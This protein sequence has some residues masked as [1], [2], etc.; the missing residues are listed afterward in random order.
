MKY[1]YLIVGGGMSGAVFAHEAT[2][3]GKKCLVLEKRSHVGGNV[4]DCEEEGIFIHRYGAHIFH[5]ANKAVWDYMQQFCT[6]NHFVNSPVANYCGEIYNLPFNMNTFV[7]LFG[8]ITPQQAREAIVAECIT[9][10]HEPQN[11]EE[12]A[13][14]RAGSTIYE[15]L[16]KGYTEKQ[17]GRECKDLP[18]FILK[19][20]PLRFAYDNNYFTDPYQGIP[21]GGY[22]K[23]IEK[24]LFG[25]EVRL[26]TDYMADKSYFDALAKKVIYTAR[27]DRYFNCC[28]GPLTFRS[29]RFEDIW[30]DCENYQGVAVMNYTDR[31]TPYTRTIEHK[32][33][34]FGT[35][36]KTVV[37]REYPVPWT[38]EAEPYYPVNDRENQA[39][40]EK[41]AAL[42][43]KEEKTLFCGRLAEYR[44]Y[45][46]DK[47]IE[48]A[49]KLAK[50]EFGDTI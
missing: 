14:S 47:A 29:L 37:T 48:A 1:D 10:D 36:P 26:N 24:M 27:I 22:T 21:I 40:Y 43:E 49:L 16:I 6:F 50:K 12:Q 4:Y 44:Y 9:L 35:Q 38:E 20:V 13:L 34:Q 15:K 31:E 39:L 17:W 23:V 11:V 32:H 42:A 46:M 5:T 45:D 3:R 7:R 30:Y 18:A 33:F 28:Y 25:C 41:Y 19:R 2:K 8:V